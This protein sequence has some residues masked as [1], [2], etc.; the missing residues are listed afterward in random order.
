MIDDAPRYTD[1]TSENAILSAIFNKSLEALVRT[2]DFGLSA[3]DF[4]YDTN[5]NF[6]Y[7]MQ[8]ILEENPNAKID[9]V[10][11]MAKSNMMGLKSF[12]KQA[13]NNSLIE[14]I[15]IIPVNIESVPVL[16]E[17]VKRNAV[18]RSVLDDIKNLSVELEDIIDDNASLE[19][20]LFLVEQKTNTLTD[21]I[22][23]PN[24]KISLIG[25]GIREY[26]QDLVD[27]PKSLIGIPSG[28]PRYD[29][30]I[31][32]GFR[33]QSI[34]L[35]GARPKVGKSFIAL[36]VANNVSDLGV[37]T[38]YLDTELTKEHQLPRFGALN[39]NVP[40]SEIE[41]GRF[42]KNPA[43]NQNMRAAMSKMEGLK[44]CHQ[45]IG[46]WKF[47]QI[48]SFIKLWINKFVG[49][50]ENGVVKD[51]LIVYDYLKMMRDDDLGKMQEYQRIGFQITQLQDLCVRQDVAM[52][53]LIQLNRSGENQDSSSAISQSDRVLWNVGSFTMLKDKDEEEMKDTG[54]HG[55]KKL[56]V[57]DARFGTGTPDSY[58]NLRADLRFAKMTE[59]LTREEAF[60]DDKTVAPENRSEENCEEDRSGEA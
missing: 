60:N 49:F 7:V 12:I 41:T 54:Q 46:G 8:S 17:S 31:G 15:S 20:L 11:V 34:N 5:Q 30:A 39:A 26:I 47:E 43:Y 50:D 56:I 6:F 32:G 42:A 19:E 13:E 58:I 16:T 48:I 10:S 59:G 9:K 18:F 21:A 25:E 14:V 4:Y 2:E 38:L 28:Y 36:N 23:N 44:L 29:I 45:Y 1:I 22:V 52:F 55:N 27:N 33:R 37:P 51:C 3:K 40:I 53:M 35:I 24:A 57:K